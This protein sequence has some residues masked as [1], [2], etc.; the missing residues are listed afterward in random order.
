VTCSLYTSK[1]VVSISY[2][3]V[4]YNSERFIQCLGSGDAC[5]CVVLFANGNPFFKQLIIIMTVIIMN[6]LRQGV[7]M[8]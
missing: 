5:V 8:L 7:P 3:T 2:F 4:I 6:C 1:S